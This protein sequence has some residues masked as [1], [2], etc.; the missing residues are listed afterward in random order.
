MVDQIKVTQPL[1]SEVS[2]W[3]NRTWTCKNISQHGIF[4]CK[5]KITF[6]PILI[7]DKKSVVL[8]LLFLSQCFTYILA[9]MCSVQGRALFSF[10]IVRG[11]IAHIYC[12]YCD[13]AWQRPQTPSYLA[14][15]SCGS[16]CI[17]RGKCFERYILSAVLPCLLI[18]TICNLQQQ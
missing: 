12:S 13:R 11:I 6:C 14:M 7:C 10:D 17:L 16:N 4:V 5:N 3:A 8:Y 1:Q 2:T 9:Q 15:F 18:T